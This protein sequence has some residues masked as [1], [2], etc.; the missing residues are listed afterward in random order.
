MSVLRFDLTWRRVK[1]CALFVLFLIL[2][3]SLNYLKKLPKRCHLVIARKSDNVMAPTK[4]PFQTFRGGRGQ[5]VNAR[6][7]VQWSRCAM[8]R[9][10]IVNTLYLFRTNFM[11]RLAFKTR[12]V[13]PKAEIACWGNCEV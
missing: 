7:F 9:N 2:D 13:S 6:S 8:T 12:T 3:F 11:D 4:S 10:V 1:V 5:G